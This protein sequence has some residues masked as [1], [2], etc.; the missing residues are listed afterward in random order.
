MTGRNAPCPCGSGK[1]YKKCCLKKDQA[2]ARQKAQMAMTPPPPL[3]QKTA[4]AEMEPPRLFANLAA[5]ET[6]PEPEIDPLLERINA[7]WEDF[8]DASYEKQWTAV[9]KMLA[10]EPE[11]LDGEMVFGIANTLFEQAVK[12]GETDRFRQLVA[13][14]EE[15]AP[16]ACAEERSYLLEQQIEIALIEGDEAAIERYFYQ[17]S[18]FTG[19][20]LDAYYRVVSALTYHGKLAVLYEGMRQARPFVADS[21]DLVEWACDEYTEK[22]G[23][24]EIL[25]LLDKNPNLQPD[26]PVLLEHFAE[27]DLKIIPE[28]FST[29][30]DYRTGRRMPAWTMADFQFSR[31]KKKD[32]AKD[33]FNF[34]LAA[35][36]HYAHAEAGIP[37]TKAEM[38]FDELSRYFALRRQGELADEEPEYGRR[39][40]RKIRKQSTSHPFCPDAKTL[41]HYLAQHLLGFLSFQYYEAA[42]LFELIPVWLRFLTKYN[43]LD[44]K[45]RQQTLKELGYLKGHLIQIAAKSMSN[46][47][48]QEN[49]ADWP[50][51]HEGKT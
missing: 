34:L 40:Q 12:A 25:Y 10:E 15:A 6:T 29:A 27:Y 16:K 30:L 8:M 36:T 19:N 37:R 13:R 17:F 18:P 50:Y 41:D 7:F 24:V 4:P 20:K 22:L 33:N 38:A 28:M 43:L 49:L 1:K 11:L 44:E 46:P 42:A 48:L 51:E 21:D 39:R 5:N 47:A 23:D 3:P 14:L 2:A 45:T 35:F 31:R 26:D 32:P 9:E